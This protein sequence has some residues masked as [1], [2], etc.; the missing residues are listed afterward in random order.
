M[1]THLMHFYCFPLN[2][3]ARYLLLATTKPSQVF[4]KPDI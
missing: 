2:Y 4:T 3:Q 1:T